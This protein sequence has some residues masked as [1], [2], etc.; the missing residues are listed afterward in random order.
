MS[1]RVYAALLFAYPA[2]FRR[3][4]G[5]Q[6]IQV[7]GDSYRAKDSNGMRKSTLRFWLHALSDLAA[8]A[9]KEHVDSLGKETSFMN[10]LRRDVLP[11]LGCIG[12]IVVALCLLNY[13]RNHQVSSILLF[14]YA[15]DALVTAGVLGNL[16]VFLLVKT[17]KLNP[18]RTAFWTFLAI[19]GTLLLVAALIG[20][21]VDPQFRLGSVLVG[22]VVS[23]LFWFGLHWAW[24]KSSG[25]VAVNG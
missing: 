11:L 3:E 14:G 23:F 18:L 20:N 7:F 25:Q 17:T 2:E 15:L 21:S 22:Y 19:N 9:T 12:I 13:G 4:Y 24:S 10:S 6:M 1:R 16:I 8:S 5:Q